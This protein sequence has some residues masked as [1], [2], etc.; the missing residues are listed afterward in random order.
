MRGRHFH[1]ALRLVE[2]E[3]HVEQQLG[4]AG[5]IDSQ[6]VRAIDRGGLHGYGGGKKVRA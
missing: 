4:G 6:S 3:T 2:L 5:I 1:V